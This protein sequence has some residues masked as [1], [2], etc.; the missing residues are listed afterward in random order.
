MAAV[1]LDGPLVQGDDFGGV[2]ADGGHGGPA[3]IEILGRV[4]DG[5]KEVVQHGEGGLRIVGVAEGLGPAQGALAGVV[6]RLFRRLVAFHGLFEMAAGEARFSQ[7]EVGHGPPVGLLEHSRSPVVTAQEVER[8]PQ[9]DHAGR[10]LL[11]L[12][13]QLP[14]GVAEELEIH[15]V[16]GNRL[17]DLPDFRGAEGTVHQ[18]RLFDVEFRSRDHRFPTSSHSA[19]PSCAAAGMKPGKLADSTRPLPKSQRRELNP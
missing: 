16:P 13:L 4:F 3:L 5:P 18:N 9:A 10:G 7:V 17:A 2:A 1:G 6:A 12:G 14:D 8:H 19:R 11:F 15:V